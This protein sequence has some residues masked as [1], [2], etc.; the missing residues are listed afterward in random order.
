MSRKNGTRYPTFRATMPRRYRMALAVLG[1]VTTACLVAAG[2]GGQPVLLF[3]AAAVAALFAAL[4]TMAARLQL[5]EHGVGI[6]VAGLFS[7]EVRYRDISDVAV[8]PVTG[9][10]QGMGLRILPG[11]ATGYLVGGPTVRIRCGNATLLVSCT[12]PEEFIERLGIARA[13]ARGSAD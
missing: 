8:G 3:A 12:R 11:R 1:L 13:R 10:L 4:M 7:T 5:R 6:S 9:L 2:A